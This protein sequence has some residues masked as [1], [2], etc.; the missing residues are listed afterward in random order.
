MI[1]G[2]RSRSGWTRFAAA[3][4]LVIVLIWGCDD[5]RADDSVPLGLHGAGGWTFPS[6]NPVIKAGDFR[7][8]ALWNDPCVLLEGGL[9]VMYMTTSTEAP[10]QPPVL[11]FRATSKDAQSW[12]LSPETPL[13]TP[14]GTPFASLETP[15]VVR[16]H[17]TYHMYV[18]G[19]YA[20]PSPAPMAVGHA[21]SPDGIN[22]TVTPAPVIAATGDPRD[23]NGYLVG[24]PGAIVRN[25]RVFVYFSAV[26]ARPGGA[27]PQM[28][29]I[30]L[31]ES[32]DG[33]TFAPAKIVLRQSATYPAE[34]GFVG[35]STPAAFELKGRVHLVYDVALYRR[36]G[37]PDWQQ[38]ALHHAVSANGE[39]GFVQDD[40]PWM[41]RDDFPWTSGE[42][43]APTVLIDG[44][45]ARLWF[46]GHVRRAELGP[47]IRRG[48]AGGE[49]GIGYAVR[50]AADLR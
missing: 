23:W 41:T 7:P 5:Q 15:S 27:P 45:V 21:Q 49:F 4:T 25:D 20:H 24:E 36:S 18:T 31:A 8:R 47:M 50:P 30:A 12:T 48:I 1:R 11:P 19:V 9:Y 37:D 13:M 2:W 34:R 28:Q 39:D 38:V 40:A 3:A 26:G 33:V 42:I 16:F 14:A 32:S 17:G 29:T 10:F 22:W 46:A 6:P 43:L 35:Y 44:P